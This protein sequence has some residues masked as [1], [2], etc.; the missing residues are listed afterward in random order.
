MANDDRFFMWSD[1]ILEAEN[2]Q[3]DMFGEGR[4]RA[5]FEK[6]GRGELLFDDLNREVI[7]F[8][9]NSDPSDDLSIAAIKMV[10]QD[11][12]EGSNVLPKDGYYQGPMDWGL[13]YDV[14]PDTL[15][16]Y[17]PLPV[18]L[19]ILLDIPGLRPHSG[20][21]YTVLS[22]LYSNALEHGVLKLD[23]ALKSSTAGF[24][25]YYRLR[26][27]RL[28]ALE[29]G[30]VTFDLRYKGDDKGGELSIAVQDSGDGFD[31]ERYM[32]KDH[33]LEGYCGRGVPLLRSICSTLEYADAGRRVKVVY[34][35]KY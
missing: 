35:W 14:R 1:G 9:G 28:S 12:F 30:F 2:D 33:S 5:I 29:N 20:D 17:N 11:D 23:S 7:R 13:S 10:D 6:A 8:V 31:F 19:Q 18:L 34:D 25:E 22:E 27:E 4:V 21:I 24:A 3:G 16:E 26:S 15:R 32:A